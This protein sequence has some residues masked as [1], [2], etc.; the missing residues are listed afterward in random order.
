MPILLFLILRE[1]RESK[2]GR[3][4]N[5]SSFSKENGNIL[6]GVMALLIVLTHIGNELTRNG[7]NVNTICNFGEVCVS[8][9]FFISGF[10]LMTSFINK[11]N[12]YLET[13]IR[14]RFFKLVPPF[15]L[16]VSIWMIIRCFVYDY[17]INALYA[18]IAHGNPF[19]PNSWFIYVIM[20]LYLAFYISFSYGKKSRIGGVFGY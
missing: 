8:T 16:S 9:F 15:L 18:D 20:L 13:F 10:G 5:L 4:F 1:I 19:L 12:S 6:K 11:G 17:D 7:L 2:R 3:T 14:N